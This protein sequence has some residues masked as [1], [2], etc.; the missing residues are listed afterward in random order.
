MAELLDVLAPED[1]EGTKSV[2]RSW[3]KNIGDIVAENDPL[4]E[5][6]TDKV[7]MEVSA[8]AAGVLQEILARSGDEAPAG[9]VLGRI[10]VGSD[11]ALKLHA[12][13]AARQSAPADAI[14]A[15]D[16]SPRFSPS[17]RR[18]LKEHRIDP[19]KLTG[20]G[21]NGRVTR[22]DVDA[23]IQ[24]EAPSSTPLE[25][26][27][28]PG[29]TIVPHSTM[30]LRIAEHMSNSLST[31]PHVT[32]VFEAD[33]SAIMA[34]RRQHKAIFEREGLNL[35]Y[36][37]YFVVSCVEAMR[38]VPTVNSRWHDGHLEVFEDCNIGVGTA[39]GNEGLVVPVV[40]RAQNLSLRGVAARVQDIIERARM[41]KLTP[42]DVANGTFSISNHGV[43]GSL[44][45]A[46][47]IINQPQSA[48]LGVGKVEKRVIVRETDGIDTIQIRP[49]AYVSL[50]IDHRVLDGHQTNNWLARFVETIE[51]WPCEA[52]DLANVNGGELNEISPILNS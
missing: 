31:A 12:S 29:S 19:S 14:A 51:K 49:M 1:Q 36:T 45:A 9:L 18:A 41:N 25:T 42:P 2:I 11:A 20:T 38:V 8:P 5:L 44:I 32:S 22:A 24:Q 34:H 27:D 46:P 10:R 17:V 50:T 52:R 23:Y 40:H 35:T 13:P 15:S 4:V 47:I 16:M 26:V 33:F 37:A 30:R 21:R 48:I 43:S 3:L 28:R 6:E 39:L 7:T